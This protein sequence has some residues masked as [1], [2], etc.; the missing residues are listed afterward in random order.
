MLNDLL[1]K[2]LEEEGFSTYLPQRDTPLVSDVKEVFEANIKAISS[3]NIVVAVL[4]NHG[5]DLGFELGYAYALGKPIIALVGDDDYKKDKM[6]FGSIT[7]TA[8]S[9]EDL[10]QKLREYEFQ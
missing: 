4:V 3:A 2:L 1:A 10:V 7:D 9:V 6:I 5:R 8:R